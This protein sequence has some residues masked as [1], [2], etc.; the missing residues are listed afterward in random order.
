[1]SDLN[2]PFH[3]ECG[4]TRFLE[5]NQWNALVCKLEADP[6]EAPVQIMCG[7][8]AQVYQQATDWSWKL[9]P[10]RHAISGAES[11]RRLLNL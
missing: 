8:C 5:L 1:M 7:S 2:A 11:L 4:S 9:V 10:P 6:V 3:C